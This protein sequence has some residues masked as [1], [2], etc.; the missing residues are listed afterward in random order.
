MSGIDRDSD[1]AQQELPIVDAYNIRRVGAEVLACCAG[2]AR[3]EK[4]RTASSAIDQAFG[5]EGR[6]VSEFV[7]RSAL[8]NH[9]RNYARLEWIGYFATLSDEPAQIIAAASGHTLTKSGKLTPE[10]ELE[11][12]RERVAREFGLQGAKLVASISGGGR[13]R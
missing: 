7:L 1:E 9:D 4:W 10:Q 11:I 3:F 8:T 5:P 2:I 12:Y 13:R 6:P